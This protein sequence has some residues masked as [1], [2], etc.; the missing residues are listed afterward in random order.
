MRMRIDF[1]TKKYD[2]TLFFRFVMNN[3]DFTAVYYNEKS[4]CLWQ[5]SEEI[6]NIDPLPPRY[7]LADSENHSVSYI[8]HP[9]ISPD[10][11]EMTEVKPLLLQ[12]LP[13]VTWTL[14]FWPSRRVTVRVVIATRTMSVCSGALSPRQQ[15]DLTQVNFGYITEIVYLFL[16]QSFRCWQR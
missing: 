13:I 8:S 15:Q 11:P 3:F 14:T 16:I 2:I 7:H 9:Q 10:E 1:Q 6:F 5:G 12:V 4:F